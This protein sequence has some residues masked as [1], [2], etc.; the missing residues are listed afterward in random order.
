M[1]A[2]WRPGEVILGLYEVRDVIR[3][4]GM[5]LV[6]RVLHRGWNV[7]LAVKA[8]RPELVATER[9][10]RDFEAE[11]ATW[12]G[13]GEHPHTANCV[14]V[15][16]LGGV[17]RVF[18]EW[19]DG[20]SLA[21]AVREGHLY[22]G[23]R[24]ER[25]RRILDIAVQTAWGLQHA[26]RH[27]LVHQDVKPANVLL[28]REGTAK[29][30]DFGL[31]RARAVAGESTAVPPGASVLAG[32]GGMTPAYCSPEQAE[33]AVW[34]ADSG[35]PRTRLT[36]A[37]DTWSWALTVLEM[38]MGRPP[39]RYGQTAAEVFAAYVADR[40]GA[41]P[42]GLVALLRRCFAWDPADRPRDMG[43]LA[44]ETAAVYGEACGEPYPR[45]EPRTAGRLA[46]ELCNQALSM[47]DLGR[48]EEAE[49]LWRRAAE[50]DPHHPHTVFNRGL[51]LWRAARI[52]DAQFVADLE[53]V[54]AAHS[55]D[56]TGEYL[57]GLVHLERGDA[58]AARQAL[59]AAT[60]RGPAG[61]DIAAALD[62]ADRLPRV[63]PP[64]PLTGHTSEVNA[65]A[66][67]Q[68]GRT[69]VSASS[70]GTIRVWDLADGR[71]V[72][73]VKATDAQ[74]GILFL[75]ID[76][77]GRRA[78]TGDYRSPAQ[79]WEL[80]T[81][82]LRHTLVHAEDGL[83]EARGVA[84]GADGRLVLTEHDTGII[85][86]WDARTGRYLRALDEG[87]RDAGIRRAVLSADGRVA[88]ALDHRGRPSR[89]WEPRTGRL[90]GTVEGDFSRAAL[91]SDGRTLVAKEAWTGQAE[92][93]VRVWDLAAGTSRALTRPGAPADILAVSADGR[94]ALFAQFHTIELRETATGRC[95]QTWREQGDPLSMAFGDD[96]RTVL[97][98]DR[99]GTVTVREWTGAGPAA[100]W[101]YPRPRPVTNRL[102]ESGVVR[103]A[104][105]RT[106]TL[107]AQGRFDAAAQ[108]IRRA[109]AVPGYQR[110]RPLLDRW[111]EVARTG[112][113]TT[114]TG[115]WLDATPPIA[116]HEPRVVGHRT[117]ILL[118][119]SKDCHDVQVW[120]LKEGS[121][122]HLLQGHS[123]PV[124]AL[125][126]SE[127]DRIALSTGNRD[128]TARVWDVERGRCLHVL[129]GEAERFHASAVS[130]DGRTGLTSDGAVVRVWDL[131]T[132][133]CRRRLVGHT[134]TVL[135]VAMST[136][137][138][139]AFS[140]A[141]PGVRRIWDVRSGRCL[142]ELTSRDDSLISWS[143]I[144]N[145]LLSTHGDGR[146][147]VWD[148]PAGTRRHVL[149]GHERHPDA[150]V[151]SVRVDASV[152]GATAASVDNFGTLRI[153]DLVS[154]RCRHVVRKAVRPPVH[155]VLV[156]DDGHFAVTG[157]GDGPVRVWDLGT[158]A[159]LRSLENHEGEIMWLGIGDNGHLVVSTDRRGVTCVWE[160]DW[161]YRFPEG[162]P[163]QEPPGDGE[164]PKGAAP[165]G[166][167]A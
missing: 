147:E 139:I 106:T 25:L 72:R 87:P 29:V 41:L 18:A 26:H 132:G 34:T 19:L 104:L 66:L 99:N 128:G 129:R 65:V 45:P 6:Y 84:M 54:R 152:D 158:G 4:G 161:E 24:R 39:C 85:R 78:V 94:H 69:G 107:I 23:G 59:R 125:V 102:Q 32:F 119:R 108:E 79:I 103:A 151:A 50:A 155:E 35:R 73:T 28:D 88:V 163:P 167:T 86:V 63:A 137:G 123:G 121:L 11:A 51:H 143:V 97:T 68:D 91:S 154:G 149:A 109:R 160:L 82:R 114:L 5:G 44:A 105:D 118:N 30:T 75:A 90:L 117:P 165:E 92:G 100:A 93:T 150:V 145:L 120:D 64:R 115:A 96:G 55:E 49:D 7:E 83:D 162:T 12:V 80:R 22:A 156:S 142:Q 62:Q 126:L 153:W 122:R 56:G 159:C 130:A 14:Y 31:A 124:G 111:H 81:G 74:Y 67:S 52:T 157:G 144:G 135:D 10:L 43:E 1:P 95:L 71:G 127:D 77:A 57:L 8:P 76:A 166:D 47:L 89:V 101:S 17:P 110:H 38:F 21:Q 53:R 60:G 33:A 146:V 42:D 116:G 141:L 36:R 13:L 9:G 148:A 37:T 3:S 131:V 48:T 134:D 140:W 27:G 58:E 164:S 15:R 46:D 61:A 136:D 98:G 138:R 20:G 16:R 40:R 2:V 113:R 112:Q 133:A 70:D